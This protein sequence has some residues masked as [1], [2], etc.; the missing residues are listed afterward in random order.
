MHEHTEAPNLLFVFAD[1]L[2]AQ[3]VG[4]YGNPEVQTP[5]LDALAQNGV[6]FAHA[7]SNS[8][9]CTP[10]RGSLL[11]GEYPLDHGAVVNDVPVSTECCSIA[12]VL[13]DAGYATGYIGKWHL[14]GVPRDRFTPPERRLGFDF[15][16]VW[17]CSHAYLDAKF[18]GDDAEAVPIDGYEPIAQT[19]MAMEFIESHQS[20]P[21]CLYLSY[22][23]PHDPYDQVPQEYLDLYDPDR[24]Q[25][26]GNVPESVH[27]QRGQGWRADPYQV[28]AGYYAH[29][30][31]LDEQIGRLIHQLNALNLT[32]NTIVVFTSDHGDMLGSHGLRNKQLPHAESIDVPLIARWPQKLPAGA[33]CDGLIGLV[34][35]VPSLVGLMELQLP[36]PV[37][38]ADLSPMFVNPILPGHRSC[39]LMDII[40][41]DQ[42]VGRDPWRGVR[43]QRYTYVE[44]PAREIT[45]L[46]DNDADPLQL[47]NLAERFRGSSLAACLAREL[48]GWLHQTGDSFSHWEEHIRA[49]KAVDLWN[50][51]ERYAGEKYLHHLGAEPRFLT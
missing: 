49:L 38:G 5:H 50:A 13:K 46:F 41:V 12:H 6:R 35:L 10:A 36:Q 19:D 8:P 27:K 31:A 11:T 15:W 40:P 28:T 3:S 33:V 23:P 18:F 39:F 43:T 26:R 1:Q 32:D 14:D 48:E 21:W 9:V 17:N 16:R 4:C 42:N 44:N 24:L 20:D 29:V 37:G 25:L 7:F 45:H 30:T 2:R 34:D 51:R 22:G 47:T